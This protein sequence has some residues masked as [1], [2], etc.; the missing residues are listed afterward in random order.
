M[1]K[2]SNKRKRDHAPSHDELHQLRETE[3]LF[4]SNLFR[5]QTTELLKEAA[6]A[7]ASPALQSLET[8]VRGLRKVLLQVPEGAHQ[9]DRSS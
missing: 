9:Q 7:Y 4:K 3:A 8:W 5:L 1:P 6:P 2:K